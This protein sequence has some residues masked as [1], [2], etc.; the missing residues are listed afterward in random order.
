VIEEI[1]NI[2]LPLQNSYY[3]KCSAD[4]Y[5]Y[6]GYSLYKLGEEHTHCLKKM[7][8]NNYTLNAD[9][10]IGITNKKVFKHTNYTYTLSVCID[11][12]HMVGDTDK[13]NHLYDIFKTIGFYGDSGL[14]RYCDTEISYG[15]PNT[16]SAAAF[17]F[18]LMG[19]IDKCQRC[20]D[21]LRK[22]QLKGNWYYYIINGDNKL[23]KI[24]RSE[25]SFHLAMMVFHLRMVEILTNIEVKSI[26]SESIDLL[27]ILNKNKLQGGTIGWGI[28]M[29]YLASK[30]LDDSLSNRSYDMIM[31]QSI[32]NSNFRVRGLSAYCLTKDYN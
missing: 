21:F 7:E 19:D 12:L 31:N 30:G 24:Q 9:R 18:A 23:N 16:T 32:K 6:L 22:T 25:D 20:I 5:G 3:E 10:V 15:V 27:K 13:L 26:Y 11:Y 17:I 1:K 4:G 2:K 29:L 8:E 28:P 14:Y